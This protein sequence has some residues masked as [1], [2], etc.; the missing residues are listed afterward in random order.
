MKAK[1][2]EGIADAFKRS[3]PTNEYSTEWQQW[4]E[5]MMSVAKV[6]KEQNHYFSYEKFYIQAGIEP[7]NLRVLDAGK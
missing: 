6:L 1:T 4:Q 3:K 7:V 5:D 2:I